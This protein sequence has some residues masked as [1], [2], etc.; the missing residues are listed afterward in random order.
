MVR[1]KAKQ[2]KEDK[3]REERFACDGEKTKRI[4]RLLEESGSQ[5]SVSWRA[6]GDLVGTIGMATQTT[7]DPSS[8]AR[9]PSLGA[10]VDKGKD[11]AGAQ[12]VLLCGLPSLD[13]RLFDVKSGGTAQT[14]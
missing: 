6:T 3:N 1:K 8:S 13:W 4:G 5:G 11:Q 2:G 7:E 12:K 10:T 9:R 14:C